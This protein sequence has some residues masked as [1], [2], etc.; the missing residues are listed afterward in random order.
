M[1]ER[2]GKRLDCWKRASFSLGGRISLIRAC[3]SSISL[4]FMSLFKIPVRVAKRLEKIMRDFLW[5][6]VAEGGRDH[7][8]GISL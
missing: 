3:L 7:L 5:E 6:V 4:Y 1:I 2:V 8:D